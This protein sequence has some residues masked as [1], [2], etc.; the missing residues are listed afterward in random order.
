MSSRKAVLCYGFLASTFI[1][2]NHHSIVDIASKHHITTAK[3]SSETTS[4]KGT[5][6]FQGGSMAVVMWCLLA[7]TTNHEYRATRPERIPE[8]N[9]F[10]SGILGYDMHG[11]H[12]SLWAHH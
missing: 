2:C 4:L 1:N 3:N 7:P 11:I 10:L 5:C 6:S 8:R 12:G 9:M